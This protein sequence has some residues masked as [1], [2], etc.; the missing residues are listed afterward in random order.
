MSLFFINA[1]SVLLKGFI[2]RKAETLARTLASSSEYSVLN[3]SREVLLHLTR[4]TINQEDILYSVIYDKNC[5]V[6][7]EAESA[8]YVQYSPIDS[9]II[10][11]LETN[12]YHKEFC[13][14]VGVGDVIEVLVPI[15][16]QHSSASPND[17]LP[18]LP[19]KEEVIGFVR[20]G[21][22]LESVNYQIKRMTN[23]ILFITLIVILV[24]IFISS[25]LVTLLIKYN[26]N[27]VVE[28]VDELAGK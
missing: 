23:T 13:S 19:N 22:S 2:E 1:Q 6:L 20:L 18:P 14:I 11:D 26:K 4:N 12:R 21:L 3:L 7:S 16:S 8:N 15:I 17:I 25:F 9:T 10:S 27:R 28:F 24:G 5:V